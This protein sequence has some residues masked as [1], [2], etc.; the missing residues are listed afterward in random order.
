MP[1]V[2]AELGAKLRRLARA[3]ARGVAEPVSRWKVVSTSPLRLVSLDGEDSLEKGDEDFEPG[4]LTDAEKGD[5]VLVGVDGDGDYVGV[6]VA[7][8]AAGGSVLSRL[9]GAFVGQVVA[10]AVSA[11]GSKWLLCDGSAVTS[12]H[13]ALRAALQA[14]GSPYGTSGSDP[15]LPNFVGTFPLGASGLHAVGSA[16]GEETHVLST[17]EMPSHNHGGSTAGGAAPDHLHLGPNN[18]GGSYFIN[19]GGDGAGLVAASN[20]YDK[21]NRTGSSDRS[22]AHDHVV[23]AQGGGAAH[24]N[25]PPFVAVRY[26]IYA[27]A[28]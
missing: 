11:P 18:A 25:M 17:G 4:P 22:L 1:D 8:P 7:T 13:A 10:S 14:D 3:E 19:A 6:G 28:S 5:I 21:F 9:S 15:R 26:F 23:S 16:G 2:F 20:G 24:N 27:G 12:A